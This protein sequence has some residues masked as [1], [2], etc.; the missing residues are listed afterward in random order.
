MSVILDII[1]QLVAEW[2]QQMFYQIL[3]AEW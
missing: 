1:M 2:W 3:C